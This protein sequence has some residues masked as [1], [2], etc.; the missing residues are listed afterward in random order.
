MTYRS[1]YRPSFPRPGASRPCRPRR[2]EVRAGPQHEPRRR[3]EGGQGGQM[4][5]LRP[6]YIG[7][8]RNTLVLAAP[9]TRA[10]D[11]WTGF[12]R[13]SGA[14]EGVQGFPRGGIQS[15]P[16]LLR[17]KFRPAAGQHRAGPFSFLFLLFGGHLKN[18]GAAAAAGRG[19]GRG[20]R[21]TRGGTAAAWQARGG[22]GHLPCR[23]RGVPDPRSALCVTRD[24]RHVLRSTGLGAP[25]P[26]SKGKVSVYIFS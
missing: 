25:P 19:P 11:A 12:A 23:S 17:R 8:G 26:G 1:E 10:G 6:E 7:I 4:R 20:A 14:P 5:V 24:E 2:S 21:G 18:P 22:S 16:P 3:G 13:G 9:A 15:F